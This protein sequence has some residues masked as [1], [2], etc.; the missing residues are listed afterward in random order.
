MGTRQTSRASISSVLRTTRPFS[1]FSILAEIEVAK[2]LH[3]IELAATD[4]VELVFHLGGELIVDQVRQMGFEQLRNGEGRPGRHQHVA[5]IPLEHVVAG[6]DRI[7]DRGVSAGPADAHFLQGPRERGFAVAVGRLRGVA[8]GLQLPAGEGLAHRDRRKHDVA[9]GQLA[10][11]IVGAFHVGPQVTGEI[12]DLAAGLEARPV[13][14]HADGDPAGPR[15]RHLAGHGP[16]PDQV[17]EPELV[18]AEHI[19]EGLGQGKGMAGRPDRFMG[20]LR[21]S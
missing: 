7:D 1:P 11:G 21:V 5:A 3:G 10:I 8:L 4:G 9:A 16:L 2:V 17:V 14:H 6:E 13:H 15:V 20:F 18:G 19:A 12:D